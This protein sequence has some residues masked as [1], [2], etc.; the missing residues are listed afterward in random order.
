[1]HTT[2]QISAF[3]N[4]VWG[5]LVVVETEAIQIVPFFDPYSHIIAGTIL[6]GRS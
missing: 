6:G 3:V 1:M 4:L 5:M 2:G